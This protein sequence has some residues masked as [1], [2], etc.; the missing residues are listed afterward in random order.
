MIAK[1]NLQR[2]A[3]NLSSAMR[4]ASRIHATQLRKETRIPYI[5]HLLAVASL[6]LENGGGQ[7]E[8]IAALL[9]D[10]AE[11]CGGRRRLADIRQRFGPKVARIVAGCTDTFEDPKPAWKPRKESYLQDLPE[12]LRSVRLV[13]AADKLHNARCVLA[14]YRAFGDK[15]WRRFNAPK[16]QLLWY[17]RAVTEALR[18]GGSNPLVEELDRV[19]T[20]LERLAGGQTSS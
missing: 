20:E 13:A 7:D 18:K 10:A 15:L 6:V 2:F 12:A 4:Y 1:R 3:S 11:D 9:H 16:D 5:S 14:D 8:A 19:V 17:H